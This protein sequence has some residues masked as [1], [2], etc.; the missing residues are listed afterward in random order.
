MATF[1]S[2]IPSAVPDF[3]LKVGDLEPSLVATLLYQDGSVP[4]LDTAVSISFRF[5]TTAGVELFSRAANLTNATTGAVSYAWQTGDTA[6][7]GEYYGEFSIVWSAGRSQTYPSSGYLL[8]LI[9]P[10]L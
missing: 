3:R 9:E 8:I 10:K 5:A 1:P 4:A 2:K 6:I 7:A